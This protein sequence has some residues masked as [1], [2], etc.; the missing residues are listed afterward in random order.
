MVAVWDYVRDALNVYKDRIAESVEHLI[1][2]EWARLEQQEHKIWKLI[3]SAEADCFDK[4]GNRD[5]KSIAT[6]Y[7]RLQSLNKDRLALIE[8]ID[9]GADHSLD[10]SVSLV[11][12]KNREELPKVLSATE[13]AQRVIHDEFPA[14]GETEQPA[15]D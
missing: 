10:T 1:A 4:D 15:G 12:V 9:P 8:K 13:F 6:L 11:V 2:F 7:S 14:E 5:Y 3:R